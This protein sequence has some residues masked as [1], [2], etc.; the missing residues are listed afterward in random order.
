MRKRFRE[1]HGIAIDESCKNVSRLCYVGDDPDAFIRS[2]DARLLDPLPEER[3]EAKKSEA[4]QD[5]AG[6]MFLPKDE[7]TTYS[8]SAETIFKRISERNPQKCLSATE[9]S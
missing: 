9:A 3:P 6:L 5:L 8:A 7:F 2:E 4:D 1:A